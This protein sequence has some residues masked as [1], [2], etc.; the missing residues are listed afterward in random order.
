MF[1]VKSSMFTTGSFVP[2]YIVPN[3]PYLSTPNLIAAT[4]Y[5]CS[6][7]TFDALK[8]ATLAQHVGERVGVLETLKAYSGLAEQDT[9]RSLTPQKPAL[10]VSAATLAA[11]LYAISSDET[12]S[13]NACA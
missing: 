12:I 11:A 10:S 9:T 7:Q 4:D 8:C 1:S 3:T 6:S 2:Y 5:Y 13:K